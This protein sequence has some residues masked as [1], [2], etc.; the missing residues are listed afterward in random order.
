MTKQLRLLATLFLSLT[1]LFSAGCGSKSDSGN[2]SR[3]AAARA[4][5]TKAKKLFDEAKSVRLALTTDS[6]PKSGTGVLGADGVLTHQ[7]GFDGHVKIQL[8]GLTAN[9]PVV[10]VNNKVYAQLPLFPKPAVI[11]P[12]EYGAP[13]PA[14]FADP[15]TGISSLLNE[16]T[17][18][19]E[20]GKKRDGKL[21]L[22]MYSGSV[23]GSKVRAIIPSANEATRYPTEIGIDGDGYIVTINVSGEFFADMGDVTYDMRL[24]DYNK[25]VTVKAPAGVN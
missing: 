13:N 22:T 8:N 19:K 21:V 24:T 20:I 1:L 12:A 15:N 10:S 7:P 6:T 11:N 25:P 5:M 16:L 23:P 17:G 2:K 14:D 9:I 3:E 4:A 18:L